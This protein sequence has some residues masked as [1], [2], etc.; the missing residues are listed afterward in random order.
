MSKIQNFISINN[1]SFSYEDKT[2]FNKYSTTFKAGELSIIMSPSGSGKTTLLFLISGLLTPDSGSITYPVISPR[3]S[4]VFQDNRLIENSSVISNIKLV[5]PSIA[6][7]NISECLHALG[8]YNYE[9]KKVRN[10]S[11]GE[12]QRVAIVRAL[13]A[14]YDILLM[15]EPFTSLDNDTKNIVMD[16]IK[17]R[18]A[19]KTVLLVTHNQTEADILGQNIISL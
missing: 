5:N 15:D 12:K 13:M 14:E 2:I 9:Y 18:T 16:Y 8:L 1:I 6:N 11:G 4:F 3:F 7:T 10:L 17:K 19:Q